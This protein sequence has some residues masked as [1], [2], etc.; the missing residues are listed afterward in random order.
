[1]SFP[2]SAFG[3]RPFRD[4][5]RGGVLD[6]GLARPV[7][8]ALSIAGSDP[9]GGAG[10]QADLKTFHQFGVYGMGVPTLLTVQSTSGVESSTSLSPALVR[11]QLDCIQGDIPPV[12]AKTGALGDPAIVS[13][14]ADWVRESDVP[15]VVDPVTASTHGDALATDQTIDAIVEELI[16]R[17]FLLTPNLAEAV[18][19]SGIAITDRSDMC[20]AAERIGKRGARRVLVKGGHLDSDPIDVLWADGSVLT[21]PAR[22]IQ[23]RHTH[24]TGCVLSAAIT[25]MLALDHTLVHAVKHAKRY[26]TEAIRTAPGLGRGQGPLNLHAPTD[27]KAE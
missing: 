22:R 10:L 9:S 6:S 3:R 21:F 4:P 5:L 17:C 16:P 27:S 11:A 26:V 1:M 18:R 20:R 14:V 12:A 2:L 7:A 15:V 23:S 24:G 8:V 19:L 25:A 13:V